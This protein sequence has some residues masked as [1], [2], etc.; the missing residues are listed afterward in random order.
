MTPEEACLY[1][2]ISLD[3]ENLYIDR[4]EK[5]YKAKLSECRDNEEQK[6]KTEEAYHILLEVYEELYGGGTVKPEEKK[7]EGLLMKFAVLIAGVFLLSFAGIVYFVYTLHTENKAPNNNTVSL[8]EYESIR[9]ELE[10]IRSKQEETPSPQVV[11]NNPPSDYTS[12]VERVMPS[13]VF[14][15]TNA[16]R[17]GSGF[18]V[19]QNGDILTNHHVIEG[20]G[21][22]V[23]TT[24]GGQNIS[25][26]VKDYDAQK[27]MA[28]LKVD[29]S[30][31]V[32]FLKINNMLPKQG[33][34]V[35]AIGNPKGLSGTVS[36]GIVSAIREM[37]GNLWVQFT[38][39]VS[40]GSSG[41]ALLNVNCEVVGMVTANLGEGQNLNF[42]VPSTILTQFLNSAINK[43]AKALTAHTDIPPKV[44]NTPKVKIPPKT[45]RTLD[46]IPG[47]KF[48]RKDDMYEMYLVIESVKYDRKSHIASFV[49][50]WLPSEKAKAEMLKDPHFVVRSG[51]ELGVCFLHYGI[52]LQ[53][54]TYV[55]LETVNYCTNGNIARDYVR[56]SD[57]IK[58]RTAKKGSR[59]ESLIKEVKKQLRIR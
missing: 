3:D 40:P 12:L 32:P 30:Y 48:V 10:A 31:A 47:V 33:E 26:L 46:G 39:P 6:S 45:E 1:L 11:I 36:N 57:E 38:A 18:F 16:G 35:I 19:S 24:H 28:L 23:V 21:Y 37:Y 7:N 34:T 59:I 8:S 27:D 52:D 9:R 17:L 49:T 55:H 51:E 2:G 43:P 41:G 14:I 44:N 20:A 53:N 29:T 56:P 54:N 42:A 5:N 13:M 15:K 4:I 58:W 22:I 50:A 25:A